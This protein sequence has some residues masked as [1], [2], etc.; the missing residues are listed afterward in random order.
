LGCGGGA[1]EILWAR[2]GRFSSIDA[3]DL[4]EQRIQAAIASLRNTPEEG[5]IRYR[6]G[7]IGLLALPE[8]SY[9]V[10]IFEQSLHHLTPLDRVLPRIKSF[11]PPGGFLVAN[12]FVGPTRFQWTDR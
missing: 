9:D 4:S 11:L 6:V 8:T 12:E 3:Y 5:L 2:T 7:N 1:N 10:V